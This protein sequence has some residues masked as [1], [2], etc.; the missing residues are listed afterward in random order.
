M[1]FYTFEGAH[2]PTF[3]QEHSEGF[4][5]IYC[6]NDNAI[7]LRDHSQ[8]FILEMVELNVLV[9]TAAVPNS[10]FFVALTRKPYNPSHFSQNVNPFVE[11]IPAP[12]DLAES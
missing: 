9:R 2:G 7:P 11:L 1:N 8:K 12:H 4:F 10:C 3:F 6:V 5:E